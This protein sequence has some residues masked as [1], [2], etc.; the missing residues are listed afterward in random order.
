MNPIPLRHNRITYAWA[1]GRCH[2]LGDKGSAC[3]TYWRNGK[4][5]HIADGAR[6]SLAA[7]ERCCL[8]H[9]CKEPLPE[10]RRFGDCPACEAK[11]VALRQE[12]DAAAR[13]LEVAVVEARGGLDGEAALRLREAMECYARNYYDAFDDED[14]VWPETMAF[15][16]WRDASHA[17]HPVTDNLATLA[18]EAGGWW[19]RRHGDCEPGFFPT[20]EWTAL[21]AAEGATPP[22]GAVGSTT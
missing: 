15:D 4:A 9:T 3:M 13:R 19:H 20:D 2:T 21:V 8:C 12:A 11:R 17:G 22:G 6:Q 5:A 10:G 14:G 1:C 16:L 18:R 7:A